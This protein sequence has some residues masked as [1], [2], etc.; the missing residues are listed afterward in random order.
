[1]AEEA[2]A[3]GTRH[4][5]RCCVDTFRNFTTDDSELPNNV[6]QLGRRIKQFVVWA[7]GAGKSRSWVGEHLAAIAYHSKLKGFDDPTKGFVLRAALKGWAKEEGKKQDHRSPIDFKTLKILMDH[8]PLVCYSDSESA[9]F[10]VTFSL[11]FF[12]AFCISELV[13][14]SKGDKSSRALLVKDISLGTQ[15]VSLRVRRSK[16]DQVGRGQFI[17]LNRMEGLSSYCPVT[18]WA[19]YIREREGVNGDNYLLTHKDGSPVTLYQFK[20]VLAATVQA[21]GLQGCHYTTHSFRIGAATTAFQEGMSASAIK[22]IGR[23]QS[24]RYRVYIRPTSDG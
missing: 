5:Y 2:L 16:T 10:R 9:L 22:Q 12:G 23:W 17:T 11:A 7:K 1:M 8:L 21:A 18:L 19:G 14:R 3:V 20:R 15:Q 6:Q 13:A 24:D 4:R